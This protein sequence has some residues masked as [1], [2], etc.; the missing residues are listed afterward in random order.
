MITAG[1]AAT[2]VGSL[3]AGLTVLLESSGL[4][5]A[6]AALLPLVPVF[7][8]PTAIALLIVGVG[9]TTYTIVRTYWKNLDEI[10]KDLKKELLKQL[11]GDETLR[12][13]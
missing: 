13:L 8:K 12:R 7:L 6:R 9:I 10:K 3:L 1:I 5:A 11:R 4:A 2:S